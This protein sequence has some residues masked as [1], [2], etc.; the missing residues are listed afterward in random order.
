MLNPVLKFSQGIQHGLQSSR[1]MYLKKFL[2]SAYF[3]HGYCLAKWIFLSLWEKFFC[4]YLIS[5]S[6]KNIKWENN[7][8][9]TKIM[10]ISIA[11]P[12]LSCT[13]GIKRSISQIPQC[14]S[15]ISHNAPLCNIYTCVHISVIKW[16]I[17]GYLSDALWDLWG[18]FIGQSPLV[19]LNSP[20][21]ILQW[22]TCQ[23]EFSSGGQVQKI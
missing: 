15:P 21:E 14:T 22:A 16:C 8:F 17:V 6:S 23:F 12:F 7:F 13:W 4:Q 10:S 11:V 5:F 1:E 18:G 19:Q 3:G 2:P 20:M 9:V